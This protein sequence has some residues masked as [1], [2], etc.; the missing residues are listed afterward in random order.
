[1]WLF[2]KHPSVFF[3]CSRKSFQKGRS[4]QKL[5][6]KEKRCKH[7]ISLRNTKWI[8]SVSKPLVVIHIYVGFFYEIQLDLLLIWL[9]LVPNWAMYLSRNLDREDAIAI[10]LFTRSLPITDNWEQ[11]ASIYPNKMTKNAREL[12]NVLG[13]IIC[14]RSSKMNSLGNPFIRKGLFLRICKRC[15]NLLSCGFTLVTVVSW[16]T[17]TTLW[18]EKRVHLCFSV[19][20]GNMHL[21]ISWFSN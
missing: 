2:F 19:C 10:V 18:D 17:L 6:K 3:F 11:W 5:V 9:F 15:F 14:Q 12:Q 7:S 16:K 21:C 1:M 8:I 20:C 13:K 4:N